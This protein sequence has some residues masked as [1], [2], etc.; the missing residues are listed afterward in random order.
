MQTFYQDCYKN[1]FIIV[2]TGICS[3]VINLITK[4]SLVSD[5]QIMKLNK[6][7]TDHDISF[8]FFNGFSSV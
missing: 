6:N 2:L 4:I 3:R 7:K 5:K 8:F 1:I